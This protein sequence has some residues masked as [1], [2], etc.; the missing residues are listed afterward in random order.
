MDGMAVKN[1]EVAELAKKVMKKIKENV[2]K[3]GLK[4]VGH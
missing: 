4:I 2:E 1:K 3:K